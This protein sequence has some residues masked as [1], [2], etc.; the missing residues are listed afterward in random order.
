[1]M[2]YK[3]NTVKDLAQLTTIPDRV[4]NK[5]FDKLVYCICDAVAEALAESKEQDFTLDFAIGTFGTLS[6]GKLGDNIT[7]KFVPAAFLEDS[8]KDTVLNEQ[9]LL[10]D[11]L[12]KAFVD[13][14]AN[15]SKELF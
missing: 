15:V 14:I 2:T 13:R 6:V 3:Y 1:M 7:Y 12:E 9:N 10:G 11:I 4:L 8:V 5:L